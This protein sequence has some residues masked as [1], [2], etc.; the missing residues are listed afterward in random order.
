MAS[1]VGITDVGQLLDMAVANGI[2]KQEDAD[3]LRAAI[4]AGALAQGLTQG[5]GQG[6]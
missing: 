5:Q 2:M 1:A 4:A 6:Q 3:K